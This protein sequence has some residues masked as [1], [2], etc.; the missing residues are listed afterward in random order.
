M[1]IEKY[2]KMLDGLAEVLEC[3][4][5]C[6]A[7]V[8]IND[9]FLITANEFT[10]DK[11]NTELQYGIISKI[12]KYFQ[13]I[14]QG[15]H[16]SLEERDDIIFNICKLRLVSLGKGTLDLDDV[17]L[18]KFINSKRLTDRGDPPEL[19]ECEGLMGSDLFPKVLAAYGTMR[20]VYKSIMK[21]EKGIQKS[22]KGQYTSITA[23]Q[24]H[25]FRNFDANNDILHE[26]QGFRGGDKVIHAELQILIEL[27]KQNINNVSYIGV[28]KRCCF[29][30]HCIIDAANTVFSRAT[31]VSLR[32]K[33]R[34]DA[35]DGAERNFYFPAVAFNSNPLL[36][37]IKTEYDILKK[38]RTSIER[39]QTHQHPDSASEASED[40]HGKKTK[41]ERLIIEREKVLDELKENP[42]I[43]INI[44]LKVL[45]FAKE[46]NQKGVFDVLFRVDSTTIEAELQDEVNAFFQRYIANGSSLDHLQSLLK[47]NYFPKIYENHDQQVNI[48]SIIESKLAMLLQLKVQ[49]LQL[50][51]PPTAALKTKALNPNALPWT[52]PKPQ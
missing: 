51:M 34:D 24:L 10:S 7:L 49:P 19:S 40:E 12:M 1:P 14:A 45:N 29:D 15:M 52:P 44:H 17:A 42:D 35:H 38:T 37:K 11:A 8:C 50:E 25:A 41:Y 22:I 33:T 13:F 4:S 20:G 2:E 46:L 39:F 47:L 5:A 21:L 48:I 31:E 30:C 28:S 26:T 23:E 3:R 32:I 36:Q 43:T 18:K 27:I 6:V 9:R 16:P